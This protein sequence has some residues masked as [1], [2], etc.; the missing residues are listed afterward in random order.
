[1]N[2]VPAH[3]PTAISPAVAMVSG[4]CT[5][6]LFLYTLCNVIVVYAFFFEVGDSGATIWFNLSFE[7]YFSLTFMN[8][9]V[10]DNCYQVGSD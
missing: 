10:D 4:C 2:S 1:M 7:C 6:S 3:F 5:A 8:N 9:A